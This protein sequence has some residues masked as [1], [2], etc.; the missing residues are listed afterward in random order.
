MAWCARTTPWTTSSASPAPTGSS[1]NQPEL[2][3]ARVELRGRGRPVRILVEFE[4]STRTS[5][6]RSRR[7]IAKAEHLPSKPNPR[8]V[9]TSLRETISARTIYERIYCP[10][11]NAENAIK[12]P[13][14]DLFADRTSASPLSANQLRLLF[15]AFASI[16]M[17]ALRRALAGT[18]L[19]RATGGTLRP[20]LL[21]IGARV[22]VSARRVRMAT[23]S[24]HPSA[25]A[26]AHVHARF[27]RTR[28]R[29]H[30][31]Q[32]PVASPR[33]RDRSAGPP[34][35]DPP[36]RR[37]LLPKAPFRRPSDYDGLIFFPILAPRRQEPVSLPASEG[38]A[39]E[40]D[41]AEPGREA[42]LRGAV[43]SAAGVDKRGVTGIGEAPGTL[44]GRM[45]I[46]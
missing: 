25:S 15:S 34:L 6:S 14:L 12:E 5:W 20:K 1:A 42:R 11:R 10:Q 31:D 45:P 3:A 39:P 21:E 23:D 33:R 46:P 44:G 19:A 28:S 16:R 17:A 26:F 30:P 40:M 18:G 2:L 27:T 9:V 41:P 36:T 32:T 4:H 35:R 13:Q 43:G 7:V 38:D 22:M 24:A 29:D 37:T 8:F